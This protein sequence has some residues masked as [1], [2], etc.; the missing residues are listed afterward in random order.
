MSVLVTLPR[1]RAS[2]WC[3]R[4]RVLLPS[5]FTIVRVDPVG[6]FVTVVV[7]EPAG[8]V[9]VCVLV[10]VPVEPVWV[11]IVLIALGTFI[12]AA[13]P[14]AFLFRCAAKGMQTRIP[15]ATMGKI[16]LRICRS[17]FR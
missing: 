1:D 15:S 14:P 10:D 2:L 5:V 3:V 9:T 12:G 13:A 11:D 6:D 4:V 16:L 17:P 8:F 7:T